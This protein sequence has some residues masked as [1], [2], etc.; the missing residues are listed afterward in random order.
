MEVVLSRVRRGEVDLAGVDARLEPLLASALSTRPQE[1][2]PARTLLDA[3]ERY[4]VSGP[5]ATVLRVVPGGRGSDSTEALTAPTEAVNARHTEVLR[6]VDSPQEGRGAGPPLQVPPWQPGE[7]VSGGGPG[8]PD[9]RIGRPDR[10]GTLLAVAAALGALTALAP[11]VA[12]LVAVGWSWTARVVDRSM[13]AL[14]L[15]RWRNGQRRS[16]V[17]VAVALSPW[18][19][20]GAAVATI[21]AAVVPLLVGVATAFCVALVVSGVTGGAP[22]PGSA[23]ALGVGGVV[24]VLMGWWGPGGASLRRGSRSVVRG[25]ARPGLAAELVVAVLVAVTLAAVVWSLVRSGAPLW[26]PLTR[27]PDALPS[28]RR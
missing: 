11:L 10:S 5:T 8:Q 25:V 12:V 24:A 19:L 9:P 2:P 7:E 27:S 16:D 28:I 18:H 20:V 15:R 6:Q 22:S 21:L 23:L 13:T 3:L 4:A 1:R 17:P 14:V 26:W